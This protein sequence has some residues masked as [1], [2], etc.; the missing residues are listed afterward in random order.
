MGK[1]HEADNLKAT[2]VGCKNAWNCLHFPKR[3]LEVVRVKEQKNMERT[4]EGKMSPM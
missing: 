4:G 1:R 3:L 2:S